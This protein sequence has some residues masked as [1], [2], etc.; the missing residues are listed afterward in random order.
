MG[1]LL[2][3]ALDQL[4]KGLNSTDIGRVMLHPEMD[5]KIY[6]DHYGPLKDFRTLTEEYLKE[7]EAELEDKGK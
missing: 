2:A 6:E 7:L 3:A 4:E 1:D 5:E